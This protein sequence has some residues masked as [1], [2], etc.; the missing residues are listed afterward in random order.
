LSLASD[1]DENETE[2]FGN[3]TS[4]AFHLIRKS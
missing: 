1:Y 3:G 2:N 4:F